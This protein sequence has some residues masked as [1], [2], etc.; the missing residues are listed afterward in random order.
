MFIWRAPPIVV[1]NAAGKL[2]ME[3]TIETQAA[4][5]L[6]FIRGV[7]GKLHVTFEAGTCAEWLYDLRLPQVAQVV[8]CDPRR[9]PRSK[10]E[11]K[12]DRIDAGQLA[13]WLRVGTLKSVYHGNASRRALKELA[14]SYL[15][16]VGDTTRVMNRLKALYRA[17]GIACK[18]RRVYSPR[19]RAAWIRPRKFCAAFR[20]WA[21]CAPP[22]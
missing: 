1:L 3:V 8:V 19:L 9:T 13:E 7:S 16:L 4:A 10:G 5:L 6:D 22:C 11:S 15:A 18:G 17:R 12:S 14:K 21:R 20:R 2:M